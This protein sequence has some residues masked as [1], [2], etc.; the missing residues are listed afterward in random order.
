MSINQTQIHKIAN[1]AAIA[2]DSQQAENLAG[3]LT[4]ILDL[5][6]QVQSLDTQGVEPL[7][8]PLEITQVMRSDE[9]TEIDQH[10]QL[11]KLA[12]KVEADLYLVPQV[13]EIEN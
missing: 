7:S 5:V 3:E 12:S 6:A 10:Q 1:L 8:H 11:Q 2:M 4:N 13:I 9:V